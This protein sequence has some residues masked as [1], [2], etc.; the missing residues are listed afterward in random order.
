MSRPI[1]GQQDG[2]LGFRITSKSM[3]SFSESR[4]T[5]LANLVTSYEVLFGGKGKKKLSQL[6]SELPF[7]IP[8]S[9]EKNQS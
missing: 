8:N 2:H 4:G 6:E 3:H 9:S 1:R 7:W 5:F